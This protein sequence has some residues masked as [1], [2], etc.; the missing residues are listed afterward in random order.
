MELNYLGK[1]DI[2]Y[3]PHDEWMLDGYLIPAPTFREPEIE[4]WEITFPSPL[5]VASG[6]ECRLYLLPADGRRWLEA[7]CE[8]EWVKD[9]DSVKRLV[10]KGRHL[11]HDDAKAILSRIAKKW[12]WAA[13]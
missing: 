6:V 8:S 2:E 5:P 1:G 7:A 12:E 13:L 4:R 3:E 11:V 10:I 9:G